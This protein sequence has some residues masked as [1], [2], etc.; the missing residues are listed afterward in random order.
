MILERKRYKTMSQPQTL[1]KD[2]IEKEETPRVL[3]FNE[4]NMD[5][6]RGLSS[7]KKKGKDEFSYMKTNEKAEREKEKKRRYQINNLNRQRA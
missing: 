5:L 4:N 7:K 6:K 2:Y 3:S 1:G